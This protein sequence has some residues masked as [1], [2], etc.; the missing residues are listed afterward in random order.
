MV[1][2]ER[3]VRGLQILQQ[4]LFISANRFVQHAGIAALREGEP[5]VRAMAECYR[6]RRDLLRDGLQALG[7]PVPLRPQ[8]AFYLF[9]DARRHHHDSLAFCF[10]LLERARVGVTPG[11]DF[12]PDWEGWLRFSCAASDEDLVLALERLG[13]ALE[14]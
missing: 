8:G 5:T 13:E 14:R 10:D 1:A 6:D 3:A 11:I 4:N 9:A 2:P 7:L 12:G